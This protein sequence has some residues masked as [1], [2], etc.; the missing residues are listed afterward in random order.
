VAVIDQFLDGVFV[1]D[2]APIR[3]SQLVLSTIAS[4]LDIREVPGEPLIETLKHALID[5]RML[6]L[7]DNFE[8]IIDAALFVSEILSASPN[9]TVLVTSREA[10]TI[11]GEQVYVVPPL[12]IPD[13]DNLESPQQ[14]LQFESIQLFYQRATA[15]KPDF[16]FTDKNVPAIAEICVRLDGLPLAIELAAARSNLFSPEMIRKRLDSRLTMLTGGSRD[17]PIR[18][19]TL[20]G[21]LDWSYDLLD[22]EEQTL[23]ARLSV[24]KGG[25][26]V[27]SSEAVCAS[28]LS[29]DIMD[30]LESLLNKNLLYQEQGQL[31]EPRFYMLETIH[32]YAQEKLVESG[33]AEE[34]ELLH[35]QY[36]TSLAVE[37]EQE[38]YGARQE[39]W[40]VKLRV[41][42]D[43][44]RTAM[45]RSLDGGDVVLGFQ[46][47]AAL[48]YFWFSDGL[49]AEGFKWIKHA[50][51]CTDEIP[52]E[53]R[54]KVYITA[55][56]LSFVQGDQE[57]GRIYGRKALELAQESENEL[58]RAWALL[59]LSKHFSA[60]RDQVPEGIILCEESLALFRKINYL[61]GITI[62][63]NVLGELSRMAGDYETA[64]GY[65]QQCLELSRQADDKRRVAVTLANL[66]SIAMHKGE[67]R[68]AEM[69]ER[70]SIEMEVELGTKYYIGL[71]F[72]CLSGILAMRGHPEQA[73]VLYGASESLL[74][75]LGAKLQPADKIEVDQY[76]LSIH[77]QLDDKLFESSM[78][79][80]K[81]MS[82]EQAVSF[83][84]D[85]QIS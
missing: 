82:F 35:S 23:L 43:N 21:T 37:A 44:L 20:R 54:A 48:R 65:Y 38:L 41:E 12:S 58:T 56:D 17:V 32:E 68:Q 60:S 67:Y 33:E 25:R 77:E 50:L 46:I 8:Q 84:L 26:T 63:L 31:G 27:E 3:D 47:I 85:D 42:Y 29:V 64:E 66:S 9:L 59:S 49:V 24:F 1:V 75:T 39:Y 57:Q 81:A 62:S 6:L 61:P 14:L 22:S 53:V 28:G 13:L 36:F 55:A 70:E 19:Q 11:Y 78:A 40:L 16:E 45:A 5:K 80:G 71:S 15:V 7:L 76:L 83:A 52:M 69:L 74:Q 72:A 79:I 30:G 34:I 51:D 10:L 73:A 2:L 18:L 4:T